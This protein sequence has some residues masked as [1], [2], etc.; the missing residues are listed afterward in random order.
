MQ[1]GILGSGLMRGKFG[2]LFACARHEVVFSYA[3]RHDKLKKLAQDAYGNAGAST[4]GEAVQ[5]VD[6]LWLA[7]L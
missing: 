5:E 6:V 7:V 2:T 3:R 4:L 1:V